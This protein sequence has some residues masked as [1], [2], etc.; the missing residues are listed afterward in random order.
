MRI[1]WD[2]DQNKTK[3]FEFYSDIIKVKNDKKANIFGR[4]RNIVPQ[5]GTLKEGNDLKN[6][7][8]VGLVWILSV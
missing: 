8:K 6:I 1:G 2:I 5:I 7:K 3:K 4:M